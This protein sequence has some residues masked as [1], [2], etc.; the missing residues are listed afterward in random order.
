MQPFGDGSTEMKTRTK[1]DID[2]IDSTVQKT[3]TWIKEIAEELGVD[4]REAY[5]VLRGFLH[6]LRDRLTPDEM[7]QLGAQLPTLIRGIYYEGWDPK[8]KPRKLGEEQFLDYFAEEAAMDPGT[9]PRPAVRAAARVLRRH[10]SEGEL[11]DIRDIVPDNL[12]H[13]LE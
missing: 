5:Q 1:D 8:P 2:V 12:K 10:V 11:E 9:Q 13:L 6:A 4:R 7:A 3:R